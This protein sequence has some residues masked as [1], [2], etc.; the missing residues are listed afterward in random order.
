MRTDIQVNV[1]PGE[2][3]RRGR[4]GGRRRDT[5]D[6]ERFK[7]VAR[8]F[9]SVLVEQLVKEM[10]TG[11]MKSTLFGKDSGMETYRDMLDG[12]YVRLM[13]ERGGIGLADFMVRNTPRELLI[14][15]SVSDRSLKAAK[16]AGAELER[17]SSF[18]GKSRQFSQTG[19]PVPSSLGTNG[20]SGD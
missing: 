9:E 18:A 19:L 17:A 10:R 11:D 16:A 3:A 14:G 4:I 8:E 7:D 5:E 20:R 13:T 1:P 12:E 6:L 15:K 2:M